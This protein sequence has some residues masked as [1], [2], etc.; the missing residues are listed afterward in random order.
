M[1]ILMV[2]LLLV[3][4][5]HMVW[6]LKVVHCYTAITHRQIDRDS[7]RC[8]Q[9]QTQR[10]ADMEVLT[11]KERDTHSEKDKHRVIKTDR[12]I[13]KRIRKRHSERQRKI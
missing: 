11:Y 10:K 6:S 12:L 4:D 7:E 9:R 1:A 2:V 3:T 13:H 5:I 8:K